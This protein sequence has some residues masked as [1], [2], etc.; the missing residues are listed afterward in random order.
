[1]LV[2]SSFTL[3]LASS[4]A[5]FP[6]FG[7]LAGR[8]E[9]ELESIIPSLWISPPESPP[10][11]SNDTGTKLVNDANHPWQPTMAGD[12]R[13][14]CPGLNTLANHGVCIFHL[15]PVERGT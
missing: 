11:P 10:Q 12:I 5:A 3:A 4:A 15:C 7:S 9:E 2:L 14:P 1:M 8:S 6:A 13:G